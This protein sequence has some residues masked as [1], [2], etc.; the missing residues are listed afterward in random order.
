MY[1]LVPVMAQSVNFLTDL[2][3]ATPSRLLWEA[4]RHATINT[5]KLN[6]HLSAI[7]NS[8]LLSYITE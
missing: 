6:S 3:I 4:F 7:V 2:F 8:Q 1:S 5:Q